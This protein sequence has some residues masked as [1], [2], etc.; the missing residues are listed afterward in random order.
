MDN[1]LTIKTFPALALT[2]LIGLFSLQSFADGAEQQ[3][4]T[5]SERVEINE[6]TMIPDEEA[7][8]E[9]AGETEGKEV[10]VKQPVSQA[11]DDEQEDSGEDQPKGSER[12]FG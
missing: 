10:D 2:M 4:T 7:L 6:D 1:K 3:S 5:E 12:Q 11:D 8:E 9:E